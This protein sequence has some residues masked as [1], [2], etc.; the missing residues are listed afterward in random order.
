MEY[1]RPDGKIDVHVAV[2]PAWAQAFRQFAAYSH[3]TMTR[4]FVEA[5]TKKINQGGFWPIE[6]AQEWV[7]R[8][9]HAVVRG[10]ALEAEG[11][12][13]DRKPRSGPDSGSEVERGSAGLGK[14]DKHGRSIAGPRVG[15]SVGKSLREGFIPYCSGRGP[16]IAAYRASRTGEKAPLE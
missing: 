5:V 1:I 12:V 6:T 15:R 14:I 13:R 8:K 11:A 4:V 7:E 9:R 10:K 16:T 2:R 3:Q